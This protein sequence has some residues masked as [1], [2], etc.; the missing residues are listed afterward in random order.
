MSGNQK[1]ILGLKSTMNDDYQLNVRT[2]CERGARIQPNSEVVT[3][4]E[5]GYHRLSY[6]VLKIRA[7]K[8][9]SALHNIGVKIGDKIGSLMWNNGRHMILYYAIPSMGCVLHTI[10]V[11]LHV[12]E[13]AYLI[14]H[15]N[16]KILFVDA[17]LL[18]IVEKLPGHVLKNIEKIIVCGENMKSLGWNTTLNNAI[19]FEVFENNYG[20][21]GYSFPKNLSEQSGMALCYTSGTTGIYCILYIYNIETI[22]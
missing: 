8:I 20:N 22:Y 1:P 12:S 16:D 3:L 13:I 9:A 7:N 18:S 19:D 14:T 10:N 11:R 2:L 17:D 21:N 5:H 4:T 6:K 15:A